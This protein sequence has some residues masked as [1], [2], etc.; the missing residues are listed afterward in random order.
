MR[1]HLDDK[2]TMGIYIRICAGWQIPILH[3]RDGA[4][5][6]K[7]IRRI[8]H[9]DTCASAGVAQRRPRR[10]IRTHPALEVL[11]GIEGIGENRALKLLTHF[12][13][14]GDVFRASVKELR[15][16]KGIGTRR[17]EQIFEISSKSF[18]PM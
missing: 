7:V 9:Q 12:G 11:K 5:T 17:A 16:V 3:T 10:K 2:E 15:A 14:L 8:V 4:H 6:A 13:S 18:L 1:Y